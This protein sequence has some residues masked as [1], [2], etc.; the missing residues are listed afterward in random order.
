MRAG[1]RGSAHVGALGEWSSLLPCQGRDHGFKSRTCRSHWGLKVSGDRV[2][3][4]AFVKR[5][6]KYLKLYKEWLEEGKMPDNGLCNAL[7]WPPDL[8]LFDPS[9]EEL[10]EMRKDGYGTTYWGSGMK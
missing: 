3:G 9:N 10:N 4:A 5:I 7:D 1:L 6:M 2:A 8:D